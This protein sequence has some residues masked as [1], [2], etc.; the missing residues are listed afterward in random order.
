MGCHGMYWECNEC[1]THELQAEGFQPYSSLIKDQEKP[2]PSSKETL[3]RAEIVLTRLWEISPRPTVDCFMAKGI[4]SSLEALL[5]KVDGFL[6]WNDVNH[7]DQGWKDLVDIYNGTSLTNAEDR[8][9]AMHSTAIRI[10]EQTGF[11]HKASL[12]EDVLHCDLLWE[13]GG[14]AESRLSCAFM[15]VGFVTR[16]VWRIFSGYRRTYQRASRLR[17]TRC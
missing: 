6:S 10:Q 14:Q 1:A 12:W 7:Y 13:T 4:L 5:N 8:L 2:T 11:K 15:V 3:S 16:G 17:K 9:V